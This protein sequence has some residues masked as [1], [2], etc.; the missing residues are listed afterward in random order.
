MNIF[1]TIANA[2]T[3][4]F[5]GFV[6]I[7]LLSKGSLQNDKFLIIITL[8]ITIISALNIIF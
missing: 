5:L 4:L 6:A 2:A 8:T 1:M 3:A 7:T